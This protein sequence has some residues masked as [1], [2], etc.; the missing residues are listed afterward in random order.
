MLGKILASLDQQLNNVRWGKYELRDLFDVISYKKRFDANKVTLT[1]KGYPY[2]VRQSTNNGIKGL[3]CEDEKYLNDG[4]TISF[5]QDTATIF[6]QETQYFTGDKI[7]ILKPK[8]KRFNQ[9]NALFFI[10]IMCRA[11]SNFT[12]GNQSFS[13]HTI[14]GQTIYLPLSHSGAI[15]F[16]FMDSFVCDLKKSHLHKLETYL[17]TTGLN[18]YHL[19]PND[20]QALDN[21]EALQWQEFK[22]DNLFEKIDT[23]K[24]SYKAKDL[25][26]QPT[27]S[28]PLPCLT[29]SFM[30]QGLNYYVP[31]EGA[32]IL[33]NVISIPSNSD[34]YRAYYQSLDFTVLSDAYAI[35]WKDENNNLTPKQYLFMVA[36]I[37]KVT[38]LPIYSYKNKLGGWNV[39]KAKYI[40][41]PVTA[42]GKPDLMAMEQLVGAIQKTAIADVVKYTDIQLDATRKVTSKDS[43]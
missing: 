37:N 6:Y 41:L 2:V 38:N 15:D 17:R 28:N 13:V 32:T 35:R 22:L 4:N 43:D 11:F 5:G 7:K 9:R 26:K 24:L 36:C 27:E 42:D 39:V 3:I 34:V 12:W 18:D 16:A 14:E 33:N 1:E 23:K 30:N 25:P 29:S 20:K 8:D 31:R 10:T 21:F 19:T 40:S